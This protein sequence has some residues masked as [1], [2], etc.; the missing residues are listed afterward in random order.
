MENNKIEIEILQPKDKI[1]RISLYQGD[2]YIGRIKAG[3]ER[4]NVEIRF[5]GT[6]QELAEKIFNF[7]NAI[8]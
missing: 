4:L 5:T 6:P 2:Y 3:K 7:L 1:E 8:N